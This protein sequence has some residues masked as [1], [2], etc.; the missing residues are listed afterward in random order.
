MKECRTPSSFFIVGLLGAILGCLLTLLAFPYLQGKGRGAASNAPLATGLQSP[1]PVPLSG[2]GQPIVAAAKQVEPAV[3]NVDTVRLMK[4]PLNEMDDLF[5]RFFGEP[6]F[7]QMPQGPVPQKGTGSG[8]IINKDG[9]VLTNEHVIH[10][11]NEISVTFPDKRQFKGKV[12]GSD[13]MSDIAIVKVAPQN[14]PVARLGNSES[15]QIGEWVIAVG[16]PYGIGHTV[17]VGVISA[18]GRSISEEDRVYE[19][20]LQT[21][22]AINPGNSGGPLVNLRGEVIGINTAIIPFAQG[23]GFAIPINT[24]RNVV[25]QLLKAGKVT[26]PYIGIKMQEVTQE[27]AEFLHL[28]EAKGILVVEVIKGSPG[29]KGGLKRGDVILELDGKGV[30]TPNDLARSIRQKKVGDT[31]TLKFQR[32]EKS[33]RVAITLGEMPGEIPRQP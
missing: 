33:L 32:G 18:T 28:H 7:P 17:T 10:D 20:L 15:L 6:P 16:N 2:D 4:A 19:D 29:E 27:V 24:A 14:L 13:K 30:D 23:I 5:R 1:P 26:R 11:V 3:V 22:A 31:V 21:D 8:V 9:Y 25:E 12:V